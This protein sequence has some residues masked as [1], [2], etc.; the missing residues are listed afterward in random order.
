VH[1]QDFDA[2]AY[3]HTL[4]RQSVSLLDVDEAG[5]LWAGDDGRPEAAGGTTDVVRFLQVTQLRTGDGPAAESLRT[6]RMLTVADVAADTRWAEFRAAVLDA[7]FCSIHTLPLQ[8]NGEV[9]GALCL[10]RQRPGELAKDDLVVATALAEVAAAC[11]LLKRSVAKAEKL[12]A[13]LQT[14]LNSR[15]IIEQAKGILAERQGTSLDNAFELMRAFA[16]H[17]R[18]RL[19]D[20]ACAV[21]TGAPTVTGQI[22]A[23]VEKPQTCLSGWLG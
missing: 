2:D 22:Q 13:Q 1:R 15:V 12:A 4:A 17:N 18:R 6:H 16:R 9:V 23:S 7:G 21:V 14:A 10:F 19:N 3:G 11:L 5:W 20:V 8:Q